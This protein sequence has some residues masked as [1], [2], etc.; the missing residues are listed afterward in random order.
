MAEKIWKNIY[1]RHAPH[2]QLGMGSSRFSMWL[3]DRSHLTYP[4]HQRFACRLVHPGSTWWRDQSHVAPW[5]RLFESSGTF[6]SLCQWYCCPLLLGRPAQDLAAHL[7]QFGPGRRSRSG[8]GRLRWTEAR[9]TSLLD[10]R[11]TGR[12][13]MERHSSKMFKGLIPEVQEWAPCCAIPCQSRNIYILLN[14]YIK[15]THIYI[16]IYYI[17]Y[18]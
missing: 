18:I 3:M 9:T 1:A 11:V 15:H 16:Y 13:K 2:N 4:W 8:H 5:D 14:I 12:L 17:I 10:V 6:V 7:C